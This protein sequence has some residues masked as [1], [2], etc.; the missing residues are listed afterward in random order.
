MTSYISSRVRSS[1][2]DKRPPTA[3]RP[4]A[5]TTDLARKLDSLENG[6][7]YTF[8]NRLL[9]VEALHTGSRVS[10]R[11]NKDLAVLG[12]AVLRTVLLEQ[13]YRSADRNTKF[14]PF[15]T[16]SNKNLDLVGREKGVHHYVNLLAPEEKFVYRE[17]NPTGRHLADCVE[18]LIAAV[19]IDGGLNAVKNVVQNLGMRI[20][21]NGPSQHQETQS[22]DL[23]RQVASGDDQA[24]KASTKE[25]S[26]PEMTATPKK[27]PASMSKPG[28]KLESEQALPKTGLGKS[29]ILWFKKVLFG[30]SKGE[31]GNARKN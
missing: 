6:I 2:R 18:A 20:G 17:S 5:D 31:S 28:D 14:L 8:N 9:I 26:N 10:K 11:G 19:Y 1:L 13:W 30:T 24:N 29:V 15:E 7:G 25:I 23:I 22:D 4:I 27:T 12:D 21:G 16:V 3:E